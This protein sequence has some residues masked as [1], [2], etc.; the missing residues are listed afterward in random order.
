MA[1][2]VKKK[3][4]GKTYHNQ[5]LGTYK[6]P[7]TLF[8]NQAHHSFSEGKEYLV[9]P[10]VPVQEQVMNTYLLPADEIKK[11]LESWN[12]TPLSI[13]HAQKN[14]G[15]VQV[16][17]PDVPIIGHFTNATW[18]E[19]NK[20]ML[21]D[22]WI[23]ISEA[24]KY[25]EG[26][27]IMNSI[28][29]GQMVETST[30]YWADEELKNGSF[31]GRSYSSIHRNP[32][33]DHI[34]IFPNDQLG[35]CSVQDGC[36]LNRNMQHNCSCMQHNVTGDLPPA[37]KAIWEKVYKG[38]KDKGEETAA[39]IAW[40]AV[41]NAGWSQDKDDN[42]VHQNNLSMMPEDLSPKEQDLWKHH[43]KEA[44]IDNSPA[45]AAEYATK[46]C[47]QNAA[48]IPPYKTGHL[49]T[50]LLLGYSL[51]K[52]SRTQTELALMRKQVED[53]GITKPVWVQC[54]GSIKILDGNHRVA[55]ANEF[56]IDQIPVRV[57]DSHLMDMD[58]EAV[59]R[60][61][62]HEQDQEYLT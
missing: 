47:K 8:S 62:M 56:G 37:G 55:Q 35:A 10:G 5:F 31:K 49:P 36:G 50:A 34:A 43:Y 18:D 32:V 6:P 26:I 27:T 19:K 12:G 40:E 38:N 25:P 52:G 58:P 41:K 54:N 28:K 21:G 16:N 59:Y 61:W 14:G 20:R 7:Q 15:S 3:M 44:L 53:N 39:K 42:W 9:V 29:Q 33:R 24:G 57:V 30:A 48:D 23:D 22:Y 17:E 11:S 60:R 13:R 51:N 46:M 2:Y 1:G 4:G 45:D